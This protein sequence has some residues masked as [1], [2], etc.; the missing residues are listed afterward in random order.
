MAPPSTVRHSYSPSLRGPDSPALHPRSHQPLDLTQA[1]QQL[2]TPAADGRT[3]RD[4]KP[5]AG[6]VAPAI[7]AAID[8]A[9]VLTQAGSAGASL[10]AM[11]PR[12]LRACAPI[13]WRWFAPG[14]GRGASAGRSP[15]ERG[16]TLQAGVRSRALHSSLIA[17]LERFCLRLY[18]FS[19]ICSVGK[20]DEGA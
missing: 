8:S 4:G 13:R 3:R 17:L 16:R 7:I 14:D 2:L 5:A 6:R 12:P 18:L 20:P 19:F 9:A 1:G 10:R 11:R 15:V